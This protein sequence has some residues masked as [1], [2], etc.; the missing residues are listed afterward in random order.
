MVYY[1]V[2]WKNSFAN[3]SPN[4]SWFQKIRLNWWDSFLNFWI[5]NDV[6]KWTLGLPVAL[7]SSNWCDFMMI[8]QSW[9]GG[10][11][12]PGDSF[13]WNQAIKKYQAFCRNRVD[14][15]LTVSRLHVLV[16]PPESAILS[17]FPQFL[18]KCRPYIFSKPK[19]FLTKNL[20]VSSQIPCFPNEG[21]N[22]IDRIRIGFTL[23]AKELCILIEFF[24][25]LSHDDFK[26]E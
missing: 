1:G 14:P 18:K 5:R 12:L 15:S 11:Y 24:G 25:F 10:A 13:G 2:G 4:C 8:F 6:K 3:I 26:V 22:S 7:R 21:F 20:H 17:G 9:I 19:L 16:K 23:M